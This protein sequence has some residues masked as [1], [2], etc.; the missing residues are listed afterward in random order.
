MIG[1]KKVFVK[2]LTV[3]GKPEKKV[4]IGLAR[5]ELECGLF[6]D[7]MRIYPDM[8]SPH[9][10]F[11]SFPVQFRNNQ[12]YK[13]YYPVKDEAREE[14]THA[15]SVEYNEILDRQDKEKQEKKRAYWGH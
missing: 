9:G 3:R 7:G 6:L 12:S 2:A 8:N 1:I 5:V 15:V 14:I 4:A 13:T 11:V 10:I